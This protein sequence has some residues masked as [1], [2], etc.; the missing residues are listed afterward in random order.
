MLSGGYLP[1]PRGEQAV[2]EA[3]LGTPATGTP[4]CIANAATI[5]AASES[6]GR[7]VLPRN[8]PDPPLASPIG[9]SGLQTLSC[10]Y[11]DGRPPSTDSQRQ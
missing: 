10:E 11:S 2:F 9:R 5:H 1:R 4:N 7:P 8:R 6:R 3:R